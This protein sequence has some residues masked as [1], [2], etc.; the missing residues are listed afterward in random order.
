MYNTG[1][2]I[3]PGITALLIK[4]RSSYNNPR[5]AEPDK[6][7]LKGSFLCESGRGA[8]LFSSVG[9]KSLY[10]WI[11]NRVIYN[12]VANSLTLDIE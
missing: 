1:V 9:G 4:P 2:G 8:N 3:P 11:S 6:K 12:C 10:Y 5:L 7:D